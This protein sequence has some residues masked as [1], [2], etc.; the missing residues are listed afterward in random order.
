[1]VARDGEA[2]AS[3]ERC[4]VN[5]RW[6]EEKLA[7]VLRSDDCKSGASTVGQTRTSSCMAD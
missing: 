5:P 2:A 4:S 6:A 7:V 1:M 3:I